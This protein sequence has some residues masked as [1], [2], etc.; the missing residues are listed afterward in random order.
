VCE[1]E[2]RK[3]QGGGGSESESESESERVRARER[4][5]ERERRMWVWAWMCGSTEDVSCLE[6]ATFRSSMCIHASLSRARFRAY[7]LFRVSR[8]W[9]LG[10]RL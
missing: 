6:S 3:R 7:G 8:L 1:R 4:E 5:R 9:A 2:R 10:F